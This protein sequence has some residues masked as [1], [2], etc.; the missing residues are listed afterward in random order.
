[1]A[2]TYTTITS[3]PCTAYTYN[4][5][6]EV[7]ASLWNYYANTGGAC[8]IHVASDRADWICEIYQTDARTYRLAWRR[9]T[10]DMYRDNP[11]MAS[12]I[13]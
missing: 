13:Y 10:G 8:Y 9:L 7:E 12:M 6:R 11:A 4:G 3:E 5:R 1:M 2:T